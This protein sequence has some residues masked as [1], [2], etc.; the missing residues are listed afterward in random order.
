MWRMS[1]A[2]PYAVP[3][4]APWCTDDLSIYCYLH[5]QLQITSTLPPLKLSIVTTRNKACRV[6]VSAVVVVFVVTYLLPFSYG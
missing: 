5:P 2:Y 1:F 6:S 4:V 3:M